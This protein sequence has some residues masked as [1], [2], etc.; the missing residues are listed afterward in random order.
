MNTDMSLGVAL[1]VAYLG[2][3]PPVADFSRTS[4]D[5]MFDASQADSVLS[6]QMALAALATAHGGVLAEKGPRALR[7]DTL[8]VSGAR[9][10]LSEGVHA[11]AA[12]PKPV[13]CRARMQGEFLE[14]DCQRIT[15]PREL[16]D[17]RLWVEAIAAE[18]LAFIRRAYGS[19]GEPR[20]LVEFGSDPIVVPARVVER[21]QREYHLPGIAF[22]L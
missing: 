5:L 10:S 6:A 13:T 2:S 18:N 16:E 17:W 12:L 14:V 11:L 3:E 21:W 15:D 9:L 8:L 20:I 19:E 4:V 1:L 22:G 7:L